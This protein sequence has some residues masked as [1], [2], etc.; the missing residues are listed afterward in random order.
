MCP[1][2]PVAARRNSVNPRDNQIL[3]ALPDQEYERVVAKM[4]AVSLNLGETIYE[5]DEEVGDLF[6]PMSGAFS[7]LILM[8]DGSMM[9]PGIIGRGG[10]LGFPIGLGDDI[11]RWRSIVQLEGE[12]MVMSREVMREHIVAGG[13]LNALLTHYAGLLI[14]LVAQSAACAQFHELRQRCGRWLLLLHDRA[15]NDTFP[16]TH[17]ALAA[18]VGSARSSVTVALHELRDAGLSRQSRGAIEVMDRRRLEADTCECYARIQI[19]YEEVVGGEAG[20]D[21]QGHEYDPAD[22]SGAD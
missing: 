1:N 13:K 5:Q 17:D 2:P 12:A 8:E 3:G 4:H 11:S 7:L 9:E 22:Q 14:S 6:F 19:K 20:E 18:M 21:A 10:M 15:K 16:L